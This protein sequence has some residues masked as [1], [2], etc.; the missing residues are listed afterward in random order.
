MAKTE[1]TNASP[2]ISKLQAHR[3]AAG[4]VETIQL[5][6][7]GVMVS[8]PKFKPYG[9]WAKAQRLAGKDQG[10]LQIYYILEL[11]RF[12][13]ERLTFGDY[14][15]LIPSPDHIELIG[16]VFASGKDD[17]GDAGNGDTRAPSTTST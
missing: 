3:D 13:G 5:S 14:R 2:L 1:E 17:E 10:A 8:V 15:E 6:E 16:A 12:D 11:C 7:T 4:G 9:A